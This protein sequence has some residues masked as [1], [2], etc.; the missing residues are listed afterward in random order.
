MSTSL[1]FMKGPIFSEL[2][3]K[4]KSNTQTTEKVDIWLGYQGPAPTI[5]NKET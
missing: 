3:V 4:S 2:S 5:G 1:P